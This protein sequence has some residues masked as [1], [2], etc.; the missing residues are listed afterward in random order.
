[1]YPCSP[2]LWK[3]PE[4]SSLSRGAL[5]IYFIYLLSSEGFSLDAMAGGH[6][7][8]MEILALGI[9]PGVLI[10]LM[11]RK[12]APTSLGLT[13]LVGFVAVF[14]MSTVALQ[15]TCADQSK[16]H[17]LIFHFVPAVFLA[18]SGIFLGKKF[19]RW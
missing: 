7:C 9:A 1:M 14:F 3:N 13:G 12:A 10:F 4:R 18:L 17:L 19:L 8:S 15:F 16:F 6:I 11:I 2:V 5:L